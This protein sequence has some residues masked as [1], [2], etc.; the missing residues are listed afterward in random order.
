MSENGRK[1]FLPFLDTF[2]S[3]YKKKVSRNPHVSQVFVITNT[4]EIHLQSLNAVVVN[5][6][7]FD[8]MKVK[9]VLAKCGE[10]KL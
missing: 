2:G 3:R 4:N 6:K 9:E 10:L 5:L 1:R 7:V 8:I